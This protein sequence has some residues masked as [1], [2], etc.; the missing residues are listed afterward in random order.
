MRKKS[1]FK[2]KRKKDKGHFNQ[3]WERIKYKKTYYI[4][5]G[6]EE[7]IEDEEVME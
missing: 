3:L 2:I 4:H 1:E 7:S 6:S 5:F